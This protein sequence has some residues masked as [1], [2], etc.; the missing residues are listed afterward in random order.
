MTTQVK[1]SPMLHIVVSSYMYTLVRLNHWVLVFVTLEVL[2]KSMLQGDVFSITISFFKR[3]SGYHV[4]S[5]FVVLITILWNQE[6]TLT[7]HFGISYTT[8]VIWKL[9]MKKTCLNF[10]HFPTRKINL[11]NSGPEI[12]KCEQLNRSQLYKEGKFT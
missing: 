8:A 7:G 10:G 9:K 6:R 12:F 2:L 3:L 1:F 5:L 11:L 4:I